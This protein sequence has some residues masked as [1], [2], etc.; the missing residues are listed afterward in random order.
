M[1]G[2][3]I[4]EGGDMHAARW[5]VRSGLLAAAIALAATTVAAQN[6]SS[7]SP[8]QAG[9]PGDQQPTFRA[10]IDLVTIRAVVR[11]G[12][13]RTVQGLG[14]KDF[15]LVDN[16]ETRKPT[17]VE[18]DNGPIG[19]A[20]LFD[21]SGSMDI[22]E[23]FGRAREAGYFLLSGLRNG[24][25]EAAIFAFDTS[26]H[27]VQPFTNELDR[28]RGSIT[29]FSPWGMTSI[30]DAIALASRS[31][32]SRATKRRALV[33]L[34][35]GFDTASKLD[36]AEVSRIASSIDLPVYVLAV[37]PSIDDPR[38]HEQGNKALNGDLADLSRWTGGDLFVATSTQEAS[39]VAHGIVS[40][41]RDQYLIAIEPGTKPGWH[42]VEVRVGRK[43]HTVQ[44]R[45]GYVAGSGR[46]GS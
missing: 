20:L 12:K 28:L 9:V 16:G 3:L 24:E 1:A 15:T 39:A 4:L 26:L 7:T 42:S 27:V 25:D 37:V 10:G 34:T 17:A 13:G 40:E 18:H 2:T 33:V 38:T 14:L 6:G 43:G 30:H 11:D 44:A 31:M 21:V 19:L 36:A 32:D 5:K 22:D 23:R 41:L 29:G 35:D 8:S 45:G 46:P